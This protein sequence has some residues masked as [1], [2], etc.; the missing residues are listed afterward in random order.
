MERNKLERVTFILLK[1]LGILTILGSFFD[2]D[3]LLVKQDLILLNH[4]SIFGSVY[5][6]SPKIML[7]MLVSIIIYLIF[8]RFLE[9][10]F[11]ILRRQ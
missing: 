9:K 4:K 7:G 5:M 10:S 2:K 6:L 11:R 3:K 8:I 1:V